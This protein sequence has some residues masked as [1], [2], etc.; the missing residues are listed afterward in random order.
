MC[1]ILC[2]AS[3][4]FTSSANVIISA[5]RESSGPLDRVIKTDE[6]NEHN[7]GVSK[8]RGIPKWMIYNG[9]PY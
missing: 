1:V 5:G 4:F 2:I 9:K 6:Q 7:V 3:I 8:N